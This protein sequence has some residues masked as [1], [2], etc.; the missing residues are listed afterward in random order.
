MYYNFRGFN[1]DA[2][3]LAELTRFSCVTRPAWNTWAQALLASHMTP[4]FIIYWGAV[5]EAAPSTG[6]QCL[7]GQDM[8]GWPLHPGQL[9]QHTAGS[10][11]CWHPSG[12]H[13]NVGQPSAKEGRTKG[14]EVL[15]ASAAAFSPAAHCPQNSVMTLQFGLISEPIL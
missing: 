4:T 8:P 14:R 15:H 11:R 1:V 12:S 13:W 6:W 3:A 9:P 10:G 5:S 2:D 7:L